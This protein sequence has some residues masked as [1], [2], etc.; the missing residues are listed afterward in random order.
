MRRVLREDGIVAV[1]DSD[2]GAWVWAPP[3]EMLDRWMEL[4][5]RVTAKNSADADAGRSLLGWVQAAGFVRAWAT[6]STWTIADEESREWWGGLWIDR[7]QL[8]AFAEQA[9]GYGLASRDELA[10]IA[11]AWLR[12]AQR[13]DGFLAVLHCEVLARR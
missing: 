7:V 1:R 12:W 2:Y 10:S 6:T 3:D 11:E 4:Y 13:P 5:H 9:V 8:S